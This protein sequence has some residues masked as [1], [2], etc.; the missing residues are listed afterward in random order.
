MAAESTIFS[1]F[2]SGEFKLLITFIF[3]G[4]VLLVCTKLGKTYLFACTVSYILVSNI[5][6]TKQV[7]VFGWSTSLGVVIY[8]L[9]Y[10]A[11]D[12]CSEYGD[13]PDD[14]RL[15]VM[16]VIAQLLFLV[17][18]YLSIIT[19]PDAKTD[20]AAPHIEKLFST[21]LRISIAAFIAAL[22]A[23]AD[24][25]LY[26]F[27]KRKWPTGIINLLVRNN[28][29]TIFGQG[30]NT[31]LFFFI[32]FYGVLENLVQIIITAMI[33]KCII[34]VLDTY[35]IVQVRYLRPSEWSHKPTWGKT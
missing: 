20:F 34:A 17:Y 22:G 24:I 9:V 19:P 14:Y 8:S 28:V 4:V 7:T 29:S 32:A 21:T 6:V 16:N 2:S 30:V 15:A 5:T 23:F 1:V 31:I 35:F 12:I 25:W 10:L 26:R 33:V 18:I 3:L 27:L 13:D 11:T